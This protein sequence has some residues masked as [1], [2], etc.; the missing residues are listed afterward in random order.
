MEQKIWVWTHSFPQIS[1]ETKKNSETCGQNLQEYVLSSLK[2][3][4]ILYSI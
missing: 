1:Y 3:K 2:Y 4:T